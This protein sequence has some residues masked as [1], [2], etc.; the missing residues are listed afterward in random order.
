MPKGFATSRCRARAWDRAHPRT[1]PEQQSHPLVVD[2]ERMLAREAQNESGPEM[3][4]VDEVDR[5]L[6][7]GARKPK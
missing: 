5:I 6:A 2:V 4:L 1:R 3:T 7:G